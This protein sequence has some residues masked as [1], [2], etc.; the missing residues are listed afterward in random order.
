MAGAIVGGSSTSSENTAEIVDNS[1]VR[2][3]KLRRALDKTVQSCVSSVNYDLL[4]AYFNPKS[5]EGKKMLHEIHLQ[6]Q[7]KALAVVKDEVV[8]MI[9]EE[10]VEQLLLKL[11]ELCNLSSSESGEVRW[12]PKG[13]P[14]DDAAAQ[15]LTVLLVLRQKL[16]VMLGDAEAETDQM[17]RAVLERR[18][19]I[20][21]LKIEIAENAKREQCNW[22]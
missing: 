7:E 17:M 19:L 13:V 21:N 11:D 22:H 12:R 6:F 20:Q 10:N 3:S 5:R 1:A 14:T 16:K 15:L 2:M 4:K 8:L 18:R 9:Q